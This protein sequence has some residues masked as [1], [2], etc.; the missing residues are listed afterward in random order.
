VSFFDLAVPGS[1][2]FVPP[3]ARLP[4]LRR[5]YEATKVMIFGEPP[6]FDTIVEQLGGMELEINQRG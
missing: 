5:D 6:T 2:R 3:A 1:L 4:E